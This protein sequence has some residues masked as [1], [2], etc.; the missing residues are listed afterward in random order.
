LKRLFRHRGFQA[1][2]FY[3]LLISSWMVVYIVCVDMLSIWKPYAFPSPLGVI[4][5]LKSLIVKGVLGVGLMGSFYRL[6]IGYL[7]A[8][9]LGMGIG[10]VAAQ[11]ALIDRNV[12]PL[13]LGLQTL[14]NI[15]W[16]PFAILWFGLGNEAIVFIEVISS[17]CAMALATIA[18]ARNIDPA[19]IKVSKAYGAKGLN[20]YRYVIIP[21]AVPDLITGMKQT[22]SFAWRGLMAGEMLIGASGLGQ[23]LMMGREV[24]DINQ[25]A[26]MMLMILAIGVVVEVGFF[27]DLEARVR[28]RWGF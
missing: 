3:V 28:K 23:I 4:Q 26:A 14:P 21:A 5:S 6:L 22:W 8:L 15:C 10:L 11:N 25:V 16:V 18:G 13:L 1:T 17:T 24:A 2:G 19:F 20:L 7:L 27:G 9:A 12:R